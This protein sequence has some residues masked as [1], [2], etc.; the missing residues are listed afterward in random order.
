MS[1]TLQFELVSPEEK[2]V[3]EGVYLAEIPGDEGYFGVLHGHSSLVSSLKPGVVKL[4]KE[5][6]NISRKIFIAGGFADVNAESCTVLAEEAIEV[7]NLNKDSL[8][9]Y[10][11][12]LNEDLNL[13]D[14]EHDKQRIKLKIEITKAKISS[15]AA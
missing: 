13:A 12:D 4:Y 15:I 11:T 7:K 6:G 2:L 3:S 1:N 9:Q 10:L 5:Q 8:E 14:E